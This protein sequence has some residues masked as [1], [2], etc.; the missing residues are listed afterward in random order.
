MEAALPRPALVAVL[1]P[2][3]SAP[4]T[5]GGKMMLHVAENG[6]FVP[7]VP[8]E[9]RHRLPPLMSKQL[10]P[11]TAPRARCSQG[12]HPVTGCSGSV[13]PGGHPITQSLNAGFK[14]RCP[15]E[16]FSPFSKIT[17]HRCEKRGHPGFQPA[18]VS[19]SQRTPTQ[20]H[21]Q[22]NSKKKYIDAI[23]QLFFRHTLNK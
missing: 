14:L 3:V 23:A 12:D 8:R 17:R 1:P 6:R 10:C 21:H 18:A 7:I 19:K 9:S 16:C 22:H 11:Q 20:M 15:S 4:L 13:Q 5:S 2:C